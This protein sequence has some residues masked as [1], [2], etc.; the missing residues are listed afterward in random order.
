MVRGF[1]GGV[2]DFADGGYLFA[3]NDHSLLSDSSHGAIISQD[4]QEERLHLMCRFFQRAAFQDAENG[5]LFALQR[6]PF[7]QRRYETL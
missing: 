3:I 1:L 7:V 5:V 2:S 4:H 6:T